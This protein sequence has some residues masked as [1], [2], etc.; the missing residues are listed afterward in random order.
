LLI[1]GAR[2]KAIDARQVDE[3]D[4]LMAFQLGLAHAV[5]DGNSRKIGDFLAQTG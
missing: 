2:M 3:K 4:L 5:L 1:L